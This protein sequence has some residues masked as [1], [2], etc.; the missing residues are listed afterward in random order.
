MGLKTTI[1]STWGRFNRFRE[2]W[3]RASSEKRGES[4]TEAQVLFP[5]I[6]ALKE[7]SEE[8]ETEIHA[9]RERL[10]GEPE[11]V[12]ERKAIEAGYR[13]QEQRMFEFY[14]LF[15]AEHAFRS[16]GITDRKVKG[17]IKGLLRELISQ[18]LQY[19]SLKPSKN[20]YHIFRR[21]A[22]ITLGE[23]NEKS[24]ID[25]HHVFTQRTM[26]MVDKEMK[27]I[28]GRYWKKIIFALSPA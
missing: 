14:Y 12:I 6:D 13:L 18:Q 15:A 7:I 19:E 3:R 10:A 8:V 5:F 28:Y 22:A 27:R 4:L 25:K 1:T 26:S 9:E 20:A 24:F 21:Q 11:D 23:E 16:M 2:K 17:K